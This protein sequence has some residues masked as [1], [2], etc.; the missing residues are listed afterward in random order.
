MMRYSMKYSKGSIWYY[1]NQQ[2]SII[3]AAIRKGWASVIIMGKAK[4]VPLS[5]LKPNP[6][7]LHLNLIGENLDEN[8]D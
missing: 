6:E 8:C 5:D 1:N 4:R 3:Q 7:P 2:A